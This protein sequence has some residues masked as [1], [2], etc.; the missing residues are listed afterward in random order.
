LDLVSTSKGFLPP[1]MSTTERNSISNQAQGLI[2]FNT[3]TKCLEIWSGLSWMSFCEGACVPMPS[4]AN[5]GP[6][7]LSSTPTTTLEG[8]TPTIGTGEWSILSGVGGVLGNPS[9]PTSG[10]TGSNGTTYTLKWTITNPCGTSSDQVVITI[11]CQTG[12]ADCNGNPADG[13]EINLNTSASNCGACG[14]VC[15]SANATSG[16]SGGQCTIVSCNTG[17]GNCDGQVSNGCETNLF[18]STNNCGACG[19]ACSLAHATAA[20]SAGTCIISSCN[21][22]WGNCNGNSADGCETDL[23]TSTNNC[24]SCGCVCPSGK[25]CVNGVCQ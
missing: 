23:L 21:T 6:D 25:T 4:T 22:G 11:G 8:N 24:G 5:A 13:C 14:N 18:S 20:C 7:K 15:T 10:F 3:T 16:C 1:R 17:W 9:S 19:R 2:I 12:L